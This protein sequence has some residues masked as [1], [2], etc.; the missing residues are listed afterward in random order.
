MADLMSTVAVWLALAALAA[1]ALTLMAAVAGRRRRGEFAARAGFCVVLAA[2][3]GATSVHLSGRGTGGAGVGTA[4]GPSSASGPD[5]SAGD[6]AAQAK[7]EAD[8]ATWQARK[9]RAAAARAERGLPPRGEK[10]SCRDDLACWGEIATEVAAARCRKA[11]EAAARYRME[12][13]HGLM[14]G[15]FSGYRWADRERRFVTIVGDAARF[16]NGFGAFLPVA[17]ECDVDPGQGRLVDVRVT[18]RG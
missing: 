7:R 16:E 10:T 11:V 9:D 12:W 15:A 17:Y 5:Q 4:S 1:A 8:R 3:L 6:G 13:T 18:E 14:G 2:A